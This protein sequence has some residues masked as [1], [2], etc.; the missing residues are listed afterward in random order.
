MRRLLVTTGSTESKP[1]WDELGALGSETTKQSREFQA[2]SESLTPTVAP[3]FLL[4][5][6][7]G[8]PEIGIPTHVLALAIGRD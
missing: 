1:S 5:L 3:F 8:I 6:G 7:C 4:T 2:H